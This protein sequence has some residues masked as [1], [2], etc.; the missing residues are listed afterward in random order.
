MDRK[1]GAWVETET[2]EIVPDMNDEAMAGRVKAEQDQS[3][4][5]PAAPAQRRK[6]K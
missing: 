4:E 3:A 2:G 5:A 6:P 1:P